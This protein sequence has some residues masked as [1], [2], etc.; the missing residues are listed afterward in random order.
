MPRVASLLTSSLMLMACTS[1]PESFSQL[2]WEDLRGDR[3]SQVMQRDFVWCADAIETRRSLLE[4]CM[5]ERG[6]ALA[7]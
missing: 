6:W 7:K 3:G 4:L 2:K 1:M 5:N